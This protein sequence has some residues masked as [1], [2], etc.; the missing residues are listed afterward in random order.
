MKIFS[1]KILPLLLLITFAAPICAAQEYYIEEEKD[2]TDPIY[3][4]DQIFYDPYFDSYYDPYYDPYYDSYYDP[5]Y[6]PYVESHIEPEITYPEDPL[7]TPNPVDPYYDPDP[8]IPPEELEPTST[9][10]DPVDP[11]DPYDPYPPYDPPYDDPTYPTDPEYIDPEYTEPDYS[12]PDPAEPETPDTATGT[13]NET[14]PSDAAMFDVP[15]RE[16]LLLPGSLL[17][18][19]PDETETDEPIEEPKE[20][21]VKVYVPVNPNPKDVI[22]AVVPKIANS[23]LNIF[24]VILAGLVAGTLVWIIT[25]MIIN[26][27]QA[28]RE[29]RRMK[30]Q[31]S[32]SINEQKT[33]QLKQSFNKINDTVSIINNLITDGKNTSTKTG[34]AE[35]QKA[36]VELQLF[37]S[38]ETLTAHQEFVNLLSQPKSPSQNDYNA[39]KDKLLQSLK[40]DLGL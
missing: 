24:L 2:I 31:T 20:E 28:N 9:T 14:S 33:E 13:N 26:S 27:S 36:T 7:V 38:E 37:G 10:V 17:E 34:L 1:L 32:Y 15:D 22:S 40:S 25:S 19:H 30:R 29:T 21:D 3:Y 16:S 12:N 18:P 35:Y 4:L 6:D 5:Y 11:Y 39:S 8:V 23:Q